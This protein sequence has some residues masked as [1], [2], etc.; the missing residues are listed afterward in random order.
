MVHP[1]CC[2]D[3]GGGESEV[4]LGR[5]QQVVFSDCMWMARDLC[6]RWTHG[7]LRQRWKRQ[8]NDRGDL[9]D[10]TYGQKLCLMVWGCNLRQGLFNKERIRYCM[11][12]RSFHY[13]GDYWRAPYLI[14]Y[15]NPQ[16]L[17][18]GFSYAWERVRDPQSSLLCWWNAVVFS[19]WLG[20]GT[21]AKE[22]LR[23]R[24]LPILWI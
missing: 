7:R 21:R 11:N 2:T 16:S 3:T 14:G 20:N 13:W 24:P 5:N 10:S 8:D 18:Q 19:W 22:N 17:L 6:S 4:K 1:G 9:K 23:R 12:I 15:H